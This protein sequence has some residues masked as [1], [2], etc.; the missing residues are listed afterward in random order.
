VAIALQAE[1]EGIASDL[2][3][4][5]GPSAVALAQLRGVQASDNP[6]P[7]LTLQLVKGFGW[8]QLEPDR[9]SPL[10]RISGRSPFP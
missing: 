8:P 7:K 1:G 5:L 4:Q 9:L 2:L 10:A 6:K 3:A